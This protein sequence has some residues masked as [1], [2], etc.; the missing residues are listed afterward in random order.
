MNLEVNLFKIRRIYLIYPKSLIFYDEMSIYVND[1]SN[2]YS[3]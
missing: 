1:E 2:E 3:L